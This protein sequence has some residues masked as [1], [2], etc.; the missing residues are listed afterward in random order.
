MQHH[1]R[2][3]LTRFEH[4]VFNQLNALQR[5]QKDA[6]G[7]PRN[8]NGRAWLGAIAGTLTGLVLVGLIILMVR[9]LVQG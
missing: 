6:L 4:E 2:R 8:T 3:N 7:W 1:E 9:M 5:A